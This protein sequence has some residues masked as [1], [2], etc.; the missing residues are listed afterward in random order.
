MSAIY[1]HI[2]IVTDM[3]E[4]NDV[5]MRRG[6][7]I[8][9]AGDSDS[10]VSVINVVREHIV[11]GGYEIMPVINYDE[12]NEDTKN[13]K[14]KLESFVEKHDIQADRFDVVTALSTESGVIDY[15][16]AHEVN[17]IIVGVHERQGFWD[18]L[19]GHTATAILNN[20]AP[21][22]VLGVRIEEAS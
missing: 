18:S 20:N 16:T 11:T 14:H 15:A 12:S 6:R 17:L 5:L 8:A 21:C 2:L 1:Q 19:L 22:D 9:E 10:K 13:A 3:E 4:D 7:E